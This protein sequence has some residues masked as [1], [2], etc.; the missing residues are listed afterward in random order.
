ML[1]ITFKSQ[2]A[3]GFIPMHS[4]LFVEKRFT[5]GATDTAYTQLARLSTEGTT[6]Q[7]GIARQRSACT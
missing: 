6:C 3:T 1:S 7:T 5:K 4:L 2:P